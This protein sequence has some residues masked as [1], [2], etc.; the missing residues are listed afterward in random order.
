MKLKNGFFSWNFVSFR[1]TKNK[2]FEYQLVL[3][4]RL[5]TSPLEFSFYWTNKGDHAGI[6]FTFS[7][8]HLFFL[9]LNLRDNR[10]WNYEENRWYKYGEVEEKLEKLSQI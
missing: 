1:V 3:G 7:V 4:K 9:E 5:A 2:S 8:Y 6:S 10:H